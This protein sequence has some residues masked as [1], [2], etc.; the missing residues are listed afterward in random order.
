MKLFKFS[1]AIAASIFILYMTFTTTVFTA[2]NSNDNEKDKIINAFKNE[3][4]SPNEVERIKQIRQTQIE[5]L[6]YIVR[7]YQ[8]GE[9]EGRACL[10]T[11]PIEDA[12]KLL[13]HIRAIEAVE[14]IVNLI[15]F[16]ISGGSTIDGEPVTYY[17]RVTDTDQ[18]FAREAIFS[19]S[20]T[21][22]VK[23]GS[24]TVP[25]LIKILKNGSILP[26]KNSFALKTIYLIEGDCA[27][28]RLEK[29]LR[30]EKDETK[31][32]NLTDAITKFKE[33][34]KSGAYNK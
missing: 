18:E 21:T 13:G 22:L 12:I 10:R 24:P 31:K 17:I 2:D 23:I 19:A 7:D 5:A 11:P 34:L 6:I 15:W 4:T 1:I 8:Q 28:H 20:Q 26:D 29:T 27:I 25:F 30:E 3:N 33:E 14:P 9:K 16:E 32:K